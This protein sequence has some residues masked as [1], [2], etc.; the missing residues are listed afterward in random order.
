MASKIVNL[1]DFVAPLS[2]LDRIMGWVFFVQPWP[3]DSLGDQTGGPQEIGYRLCGHCD[4]LP[5]PGLSWP[6]ASDAQASAFEGAWM[7]VE[8]PWMSR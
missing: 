1:D 5:F 3:S 8:G 2:I 7:S 6:P 4:W